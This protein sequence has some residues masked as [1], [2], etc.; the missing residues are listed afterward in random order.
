M[1]TL[2][3]L[4][5]VDGCVFC[6]EVGCQGFPT[7][8]PFF[9]G[10]GRQVFQALTGQ[11][12]IVVEGARGASGLNPGSSLQPGLGGRP[13]LQIQ[14]TRSLGNGSLAVCD[15]QPPNA[16]G[17]PAINPPSYNPD[18]P[19]VTNALNDFACRF[20][21]FP[22]SSPCTRVDASGESRYINTAADLQYCH[23]VS[24]SA[25]FPPGES[26]LTVRLRDAIGNVGPTAQVVIRVAT[27]TPT[28]AP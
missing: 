28:P 19:F 10:Q 18:S 3:I 13:D 5:R 2:S 17:V 11:F 24:R 1:L 20:E 27:P 23:T 9:D 25:M 6:C 4:S 21:V 16:G 12:M 8:V 15:A 7:P 14:S 22:R 26:I